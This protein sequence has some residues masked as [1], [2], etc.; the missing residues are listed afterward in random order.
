MCI[1]WRSN[2]HICEY[3]Y[4]SSLHITIR[5]VLEENRVELV[6]ICCIYYNVDDCHHIL[7]ALREAGDLWVAG[8]VGCKVDELWQSS[9]GQLS[10]RGDHRKSETI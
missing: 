6:G 5:K 1:G 7:E 2:S 10:A 3:L 4:H 9:F 8:V